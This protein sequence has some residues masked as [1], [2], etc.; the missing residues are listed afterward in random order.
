[1]KPQELLELLESYDY[2][3]TGGNLDS[4]GEHIV[5]TYLNRVL[6]NYRHS[7]SSSDIPDLNG[8]IYD[9]INNS[10]PPNV[11]NQQ[12]KYEMPN[13]I[14]SHEWNIRDIAKLEIEEANR[15]KP[16]LYVDPKDGIMPEG[17]IFFC[18]NPV[19]IKADEVNRIDMG[20]C[21]S[22]PDEYS[23]NLTLLPEFKNDITLLTPALDSND[24]GRL[25]LEI[26][27]KSKDNSINIRKGTGLV[28]G[29]MVRKC[30]IQ[31]ETMCLDE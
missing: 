28:S 10:P 21:V 19:F 3:H 16:V 5:R 1:M 18:G 31:I 27:N 6:S 26:L 23:L 11:D 17:N 7:Y 4:L 25:F 12:I 8:I 13:L 24:N 15:Y 20:I 2:T 29:Q 14:S 9:S 22:I 30:E